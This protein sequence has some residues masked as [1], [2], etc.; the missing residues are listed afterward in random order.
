MYIVNFDAILFFLIWT[1]AILTGFNKF[2]LYEKDI[3]TKYIFISRIWLNIY[4]KGMVM[5]GVTWSQKVLKYLLKHLSN[6]FDYD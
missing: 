5:E 2:K 6:S 3:F 1:S 4:R